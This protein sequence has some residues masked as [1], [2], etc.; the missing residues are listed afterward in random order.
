M[1]KLDRLRAGIKRFPP[2]QRLFFNL[3]AE[4]ELG[5]AVAAAGLFFTHV[6]L[7]FETPKFPGIRIVCILLDAHEHDKAR[8][9]LSLLKAYYPEDENV[10]LL[11][12]TWLMRMAR[13]S[14]AERRFDHFFEALPDKSA[15]L[16]RH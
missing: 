11:D 16:P 8:V 13:F 3:V 4:I 5:H 10:R 2:R 12:V 14:E 7:Y 6:R 1:A 9:I 15:A